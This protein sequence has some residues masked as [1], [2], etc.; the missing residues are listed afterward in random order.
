MPCIV[1]PGGPLSNLR[2]LVPSLLFC[3]QSV[4]KKSIFYQSVPKNIVD[5]SHHR[6]HRH[7]CTFIKPLFLL[8]HKNKT[9]KFGPFRLFC[10]E[11]MHFLALIVWWCP[12]IDKYQVCQRSSSISPKEVHFLLISPKE[13]HFLFISPKEAHFLFISPK[14]VHFSSL[15]WETIPKCWMILTG[16]YSGKKSNGFSLFENLSLV[17][18]I[19]NWIK[20]TAW[21]VD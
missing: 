6:H 10:H 19:I 21:C 14:E 13:A 9:L 17:F 4:P 20:K 18:C 12:K 5:V 2:R 3:Y 1:R 11:F 8:E 7:W 16:I 15:L